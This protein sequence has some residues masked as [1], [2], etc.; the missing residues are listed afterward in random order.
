MA[1]PA[2]RRFTPAKGEVLAGRYRL[3]RPLAKGG[4][5]MVWR[6]QHLELELPVAVKFMEAPDDL[7]NARGRF[8]RRRRRPSSGARTWS[9]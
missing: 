9:R 2:E 8:E 3:E 5:G 6:A 1:V 7:P 4:M